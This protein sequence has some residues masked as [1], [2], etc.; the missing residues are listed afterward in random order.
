MCERP[1]K[2]PAMKSEVQRGVSF[3]AR[4]V[5]EKEP[6]PTIKKASA[7]ALK[8]TNTTNTFVSLMTSGSPNSRTPRDDVSVEWGDL[9]AVEASYVTI[10]DERPRAIVALTAK[11]EIAPVPSLA[12]EDPRAIPT[13]RDDSAFVRHKALFVDHWGRSALTDYS[14]TSALGGD[15]ARCEH[16]GNGMMSCERNADSASFHLTM[17]HG[18]IV[19]SIPAEAHKQFENAYPD[20]DL[21]KDIHVTVD[22]VL[23]TED[24]D[25]LLKLQ[26]MLVSVGCYTL[27]ENVATRRL[28]LCHDVLG[29]TDHGTRLAN[30]NLGV[31]LQHAGLHMD[32]EHCFN[33][34]L[35]EDFPSAS[36]SPRQAQRLRG[37]NAIKG[38]K[39]V[40]APHCQTTEMELSCES[41]VCLGVA[42][43]EQGRLCQASEHLQG[44][45]DAAVDKF[46]KEHPRTLHAANELG[47]TLLRQNRVNDAAPVVEQVVR[48]LS[49]ILGSDHLNTV[50]ALTN[51]AALQDAQGNSDAATSAYQQ[52]L[53]KLRVLYGMSHP[54]TL[55][56]S[57]LM[58]IHGHDADN[59]LFE[60][61]VAS[62]SAA[63]GPTSLPTLCAEQDL[64]VWHCRMQNYSAALQ[65]FQRALIEF[66]KVCGSNHKA[67]VDTCSK[68]FSTFMKQN[69]LAEADVCLQSV[70]AAVKVRCGTENIDTCKASN[71]VGV[72]QLRRF[73]H[74]EAYDVLQVDCLRPWQ[75]HI[76]HTKTPLPS[77]TTPS[78]ATEDGVCY[79]IAL[80][81]FAFACLEKNKWKEAERSCKCAWDELCLMLGP[82]HP[83][84]LT[85]MSNYGVALKSSRNLSESEKIHRE[86][87]TLREKLLGP[88]D[89]ATLE[90]YMNLGLVLKIAGKLL[91][92]KQLQLHAYNK[93]VQVV[94]NCHADTLNSQYYLALLMLAEENFEEAERFLHDC[95]DG[96]AKIFGD[97]STMYWH[98][99][100]LI[101]LVYTGYKRDD[102]ALDCHRRS[103]DGL[104]RSIG[105]DNSQTLTQKT[106]VAIKLWAQGRLKETLE[107]FL[108]TLPAW[109]ALVGATHPSSLVTAADIGRL[110]Y[111][112]DMM[113][114]SREYIGL[115]QDG[116]DQMRRGDMSDFVSIDFD[117]IMSVEET[118]RVYGPATSSSPLR[119]VGETISRWVNW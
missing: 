113:K 50:N 78:T 45:Y 102:D 74:R 55:A 88:D 51:L 93:R 31:I 91:E 76:V 63:R 28:E 11:A 95:M 109:T 110:Y 85:A 30:H 7:F 35:K 84:T 19:G 111:A 61:L 62:W 16:N 56:C 9:L 94:G 87:I 106:N 41:A 69:N 14:S 77:R 67:T 21:A 1:A 33:A 115:A 57:R 96:C 65:S 17:R 117:K 15:G 20:F 81:N 22:D 24:L 86:V 107:M 36:M 39:M 44:I 97:N 82:D 114:E 13:I 75:R 70:A 54:K 83:N 2:A 43:R 80:Q 23:A 49:A 105:P 98:C 64:G 6:Q 58:A 32:A 12:I 79:Q 72:M 25:V 103:A 118:L 47:A 71:N 18:P 99:L 26:T 92:A 46:G 66:A 48:Q 8:R 60:Q 119:R 37:V 101:G 100:D 116:F 108:D 59:F 53:T 104:S 4:A 112:L 73:R 90:S 3:A 29:P 38:T 68:L 52:V 42:L 40:A 5:K 89:L 34:A 27:A 10:Q